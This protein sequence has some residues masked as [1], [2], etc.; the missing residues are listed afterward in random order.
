YGGLISFVLKNRKKTPRFYDALR[1]SKG[2][3]LG[4]EFSLACPYTM[5]AHYDEM[6][7]VEGCGLDKYLIRISIG[8]EDTN[9]LLSR[10]SEA[11]KLA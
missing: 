1:I 6:E 5:L 4:T 3:S 8:I 11:L 2:P 9:D 7:W 10:M